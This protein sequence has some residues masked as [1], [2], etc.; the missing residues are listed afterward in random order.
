MDP[1]PPRA[2][3]RREGRPEARLTMDP[4]QALQ[5]PGFHQLQPLRRGVG[6]VAAQVARDLPDAEAAG[7]PRDRVR[8]GAR[9][10]R[11]G[12][13]RSR[14]TRHRDEPRRHPDPRARGLRVPAGDLLAQVGAVPLG[15]RRDQDLQAA[16]QG[17]PHLRADRRRRTGRVGQARDRRPGVL[18]AG[19]HLPDGC[20]RRAD[21][22]SPPSRSRRTC[23][24]ARTASSTSS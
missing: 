12:V 10:D 16:G 24:R 18:P 9:P 6:E 17:Q 11:A 22:T 23:A 7:R 19:A 20:E 13:P 1:D 4:Q 15:Q 5:V 2:V 3:D 14:R 8:S 21:Q